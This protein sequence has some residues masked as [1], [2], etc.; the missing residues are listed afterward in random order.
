MRPLSP[1]RWQ[2]ICPY[3]DQALTIDERN[4]AK[5]LDEIRSRDADL[6]GDLEA[7]LIE[8]RRA[9]AAG[10]LE[11]SLSGQAPPVVAGQEIG[12]YRLL[13][14]I[15]EGGMGTVWLAERVDGRFQ[16]RVA[17]KFLAV[18][19]ASRIGQERFKREGSILGALAHPH[20]AHLMDAGVSATGRPYLV[21]EYVAGDDIARHCD[22]RGLDVRARVGLFLD[23]LSA[24]AHAHGHL[25]VHRDLKP[26]NILVNAAGEVKL[27]DFGIA[28][29]LENGSER[30]DL[31]E[32]T[33]EGGPPLT[34]EYA[35][36]EQARGAPQTTAT[37]IYSAGAVLYR[38][39]AGRSPHTVRTA[40]GE[41]ILAPIGAEPPPASRLN[42]EVPRDLDF[43]LA[44]A[45]RPDPIDRYHSVDTFAEDL[46]AFLEWRPVRARAGTASYRARR[47]VRR[48]RVPLSAVALTILG[49]TAG[50]VVA[51]RQRT[52]AQRR[53]LQVRQLANK[54]IDLDESLRGLP[55]ATKLRSQIV[56]D[57]LQYLSALGNETEVDPDL[58]LEIA[59]AYV[60]VAHA[61]GDPTSANLG[62]FA[63]AEVNQRNVERFLNA[64]LA[65]NPRNQQA[66]FMSAGVAHDLMLLADTQGRRRDVLVW[67]QKA[68][69]RL[70]HFGEIGIEPKW[71]YGVTYLYGNIAEAFSSARRFDDAERYCR[72]ALDIARPDASA[73]KLEGNVLTS[74]ADAQWQSGNLDEALKT[75]ET[76]LVRQEEAAAGGHA[77][78]RANVITA[79]WLKG[80][81]LG[82]ADAEPSLGRTAEALAAFQRALDL[83][84]ESA[85]RDPSDNLSRHNVAIVALQLGNLVRHTNPQKAL[86]VYD[87]ALARIGEATASAETARDRAELLAG[88]SYAART[89]GRAADARRRV[90]AA[91]RALQDGTLNLAESI[92]PMSDA[93][94]VLR[95]QADDCDAAGETA[96]ALALYGTLL[97]KLTAWKP[98]VDRDA[99]D[100]V[101][102][103]RT[104]LAIARLLRRTGR[105][106]DAASYE[107]RNAD[108]RLQW[109]SKAPHQAV[110]SQLRTV[111]ASF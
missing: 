41:A 83:A 49:L 99:R 63:E 9:V 88:S 64:V 18:S 8:H 70:R 73:R 13:S 68:A 107:S 101:C 71:V 97:E 79:L 95:A 60:R 37:D 85:A 110:L 56:A 42:A 105:A 98:N 106:D 25:I 109:A 10:Y 11:Q 96:R 51:N 17:I 40:A 34:P 90:D 43:V 58:A 45:L 89:V 59:L 32:L 54:F 66:L 86:V 44:K 61:Q 52:E 20:I 72:Q 67:A 104:W 80:M 2:A 77:T 84:E 55:G 50:V 62:R 78:L 47:F 5:W 22:A 19:L 1:E 75:A 81:I 87:R 103:S 111:G 15:G 6:A 35:S 26:S 92:E 108:L 23:V 27:L 33:R 3:L 91:L 16:G 21:L 100:A 4:R 65:R 74:L 14:P 93:D 39:L 82:K 102:L 28:K 36:P 69:E 38:L 24:V 7:L 94:H 53:F 30:G 57:A 48:S 76:A 31:P 29:L 46:R 12:A